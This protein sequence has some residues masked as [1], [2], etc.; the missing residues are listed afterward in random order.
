MPMPS[1][2]AHLF[3]QE[4]LTFGHFQ[5]VA[6]AGFGQVELWAMKPN[7]DCGDPAA[8]SRLKRWLADLSLEAPSFHAP[9]YTHLD[10]A[11]TG[12][13]LSLAHSEPEQRLE[14]INEI[15]A[16]LI[17]MANLDARIAV[18]HPSAPGSAGEG[19]TADGFMQSIERLIPIAEHLNLTLAVENIPA[20][21]GGAEQIGALIERIGHPCVRACLDSGHAFLTEGEAAPEAFRRLAPLAAATH[22]H[23]N[24]G[25]S[26]GHLI[27]GEGQVP[28]PA[29]WRA[30]DETGYEGPL[31][32]ELRPRE[33]SDYA[34]H[35]NE[36]AQAAPLAAAGL[37]NS[38]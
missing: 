24:D 17:A 20:P 11:R 35:L 19:D 15:Q 34:S 29:L 37:G 33:N 14:A 13:W 1:L 4:P 23:D 31:T 27:P 30:L 7:L 8:M 3:A 10:R 9:F 28:F 5:A 32:F 36:L 22:L 18:L 25:E 26:D 2:S 6:E 38:S 12:N 16:S 21:L